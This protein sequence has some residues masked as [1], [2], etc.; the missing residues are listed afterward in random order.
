MNNHQLQPLGGGMVPPAGIGSLGSLGLP[1]PRSQVGRAVTKVR[2][3]G[4]VRAASIDTEAALSRVKVSAAS[5]LA[6]AAQNEVALLT[7]MEAELIKAVPLAVN[8]LELVSN[9]ASIQIAE[10][11]GD[12]MT[13]LRR[14]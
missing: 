1:S 5:S 8:R 2:D 3:Q 7:G 12:S 4:L 10:L 13:T 9:L 6:R 14:L 11:L